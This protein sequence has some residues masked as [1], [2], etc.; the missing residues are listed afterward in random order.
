[1]WMGLYWKLLTIRGV[2]LLV[3]SYIYSLLYIYICIIEYNLQIMKLSL[4]I[5]HPGGFMDHFTHF[6]VKLQPTLYPQAHKWIKLRYPS[7]SQQ[8][9][10]HRGKNNRALK[11][12]RAPGE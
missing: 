4:G 3:M 1:M 6:S 2:S 8:H 10:A 7:Y 5:V 9:F 11:E 12:E